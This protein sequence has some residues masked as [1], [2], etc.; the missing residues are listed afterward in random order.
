M[1]VKGRRTLVAKEE[2]RVVKKRKEDSEG[3]RQRWGV[4]EGRGNRKKHEQRRGRSQR[5]KNSNS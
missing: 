4:T 5:E 3:K 2:N 1:D